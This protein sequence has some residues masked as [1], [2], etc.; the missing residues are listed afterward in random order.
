M[1]SFEKRAVPDLRCSRLWGVDRRHRGVQRPFSGAKLCKAWP[2]I[3]RHQEKNALYSSTWFYLVAVRRVLNRVPV[4]L[5]CHW[6]LGRATQLHE[7]IDDAAGPKRSNQDAGQLE[8]VDL[9]G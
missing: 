9:R 8:L 3:S 5:A 6:Y 4:G 2:M 7:E 1:S